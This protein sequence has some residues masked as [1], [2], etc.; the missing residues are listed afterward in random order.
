M[1]GFCDSVCVF[2]IAA[3][4]KKNV[5]VTLIYLLFLVCG[6]FTISTIQGNVH[7]AVEPITSDFQ[8][9]QPHFW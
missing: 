4:Y 5:I 8:D 9:S 3:L 7:T 1:T 6:D 2:H